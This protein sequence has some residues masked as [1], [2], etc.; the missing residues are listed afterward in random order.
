[1][2]TQLEAIKRALE[3]GTYSAV[4][5][6]DMDAV[7]FDMGRGVVAEYLALFGAEQSAVQAEG[8]A[9]IV[10]T[11]DWGGPNSGVMIVR[12]TEW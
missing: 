9:D 8:S 4:F 10:M 3:G 2:S 1:M 7:I 11:A 5:Y 12:N 6:I